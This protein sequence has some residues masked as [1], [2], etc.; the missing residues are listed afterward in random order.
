MEQ[1]LFSIIESKTLSASKINSITKEAFT[2]I[3]KKQHKHVVSILTDFIMT[4]PSAFKL[5]ACYV[6]D[7]I[8][9]SIDSQLKRDG[10]SGKDPMIQIIENELESWM[11]FIIQSDE[12]DKIKKLF[13]LWRKV[14]LFD[15]DKL[16][17]L[18]KTWFKS[19]ENSAVN[20][21]NSHSNNNNNQ[22]L[23]LN[24]NALLSILG[25][26]QQ[27]AP[28]PVSPPTIVGLD[29]SLVAQFIQQPELLQAYTKLLEQQ[30]L[31]NL[32]PQQPANNL[33]SLQQSL[34]MLPQ[35]QQQPIQQ[36]LYS[37]PPARNEYHKHTNEPYRKPEQFRRKIASADSNEVIPI[38]DA[39][40]YTYTQKEGGCDTDHILVLSRTLYVGGFNEE[41]NRQD[42]MDYFGR[43]GPVDSIIMTMKKN[44][45]F[46]KLRTRDIASVALKSTHLS[47]LKG[48]QLKVG[49][50]LI[51]IG[52]GCGFG[53][54]DSFDYR[55]GHSVI[56]LARLTNQDKDWLINAP[57]G[58]IQEGALRG[59]ITVEEPHI[60]DFKKQDYIAKAEF[61]AVH[62][63]KT[64]IRNTKPPKASEDPSL[65][66]AGI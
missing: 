31:N 32:Q 47:H 52:F 15:A 27:Q 46:I 65:N 18:L 21:T 13:E 28:Q 9:R 14:K 56:P 11:P 61:E 36:Q 63:I 43:F 41:V 44:N 54:K 51:N 22:S 8:A 45:A 50:L 53:P 55:S 35:Q 59:G 66:F 23:N 24:N 58:G 25:N 4:C 10:I 16:D 62:N 49:N 12:V 17:E 7:G 26:V 20:N 64:D 3:A 30:L 19:N 60:S 42:L 29:P 40:Q 5:K 48:R 33:F 2:L 39:D 1:Q 6:I 38:T 37:H 57:V 34:N